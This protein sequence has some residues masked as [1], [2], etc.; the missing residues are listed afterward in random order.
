MLRYASLSLDGIDVPQLVGTRLDQHHVGATFE[1]RAPAVLALKTHKCIEQFRRKEHRARR[2]PLHA[3]RTGCLRPRSSNA[4]TIASKE[5]ELTSGW[6]P[7]KK[8]QPFQL[9]STPHERPAR[10]LS[11]R[12]SPSCS[13][14]GQCLSS[15]IWA[16]SGQRVETTTSKPRGTESMVR[17]I[18]GSHRYRRASCWSQT[19]WPRPKP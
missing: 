5:S 2:S 11:L 7:G 15:Q 17:A 12:S 9:R 3:R 4:R 13:T 10:T 8:R 14:H 19:A 16:T 1:N 18:S 6:S